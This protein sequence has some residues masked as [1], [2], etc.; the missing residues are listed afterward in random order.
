[1]KNCYLFLATGFEEIEATTTIDILRRA[2][3]NLI[4]V[5]VE[6]SLEVKGAHDIVMRADTLLKDN[7]YTDNRILILPGGTVRLGEFDF[8]NNL[9]VEQNKAGKTIA[10][11]CAAPSLL[12]RL[13]ILKGKEATCYPSFEVYL[14]G[15]T[16]VDKRVAVSQNIITGKGPGCTKEFAL[17]IVETLLGQEKMSEVAEALIA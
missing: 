14:D 8:L 3:L 13:G 5:S 16:F 4:T 15:A 6:D 11:I 2:G 1:M 12:G 9:L 17:K 10:A 7:D